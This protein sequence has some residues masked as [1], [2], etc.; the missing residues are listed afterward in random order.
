MEFFSSYHCSPGLWVPL[1]APEDG[2]DTSGERWVGS[3]S[4]TVHSVTG[5]R[6]KMNEH[7]VEQPGPGA[8]SLGRCGSKV[9]KM[10][11]VLRTLC[12]RASLPH[13][14]GIT[15]PTYRCMHTYVNMRKAVAQITT[16][17]LYRESC[18]RYLGEVAHSSSSL[19]EFVGSDVHIPVAKK[20]STY[21]QVRNIGGQ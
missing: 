9:Q 4:V 11:P 10:V 16:G 20:S 15:A 3:L 1:R 5:S 2:S 18:M 14:R 19:A 7:G 17:S 8:P 12:C 21:N 6:K 13:S